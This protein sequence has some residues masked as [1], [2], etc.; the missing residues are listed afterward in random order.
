[1]VV[2]RNRLLGKYHLFKKIKDAGTAEEVARTPLAEE[3][4]QPEITVTPER[5]KISLNGTETDNGRRTDETGGDGVSSDAISSPDA[6][7][8]ANG[9]GKGNLAEQEPAEPAQDTLA[10]KGRGRPRKTP[11][12]EESVAKTAQKRSPA[13]TYGATDK[14]WAWNRLSKNARIATDG[15]LIIRYILDAQLFKDRG[16]ITQICE[17]DMDTLVKMIYGRARRCVYRECI[18]K[19]G[20]HLGCNYNELLFKAKQWQD[21]E[22]DDDTVIQVRAIDSQTRNRFGLRKN[23]LVSLGFKPADMVVIEQ[24]NDF[25][26]KSEGIRKGDI[27]LINKNDV[28][29]EL[30]KKYAAEINEKFYVGIGVNYQGKNMFVVDPSGT[31]FSNQKF[32][33]TKI[34]GKAVWIFA[35]I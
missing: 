25:M 18:D 2:V 12:E 3:Q 22:E 14:T 31:K 11:D 19:M 27:L 1:M 10:R 15:H 28:T 13:I 6:A 23:W 32:N 35:A 20:A 24:N 5:M 34:V 21:N 16:E 26:A 33:Q 30:G 9:R 8:A 17:C 29:F 7:R 4:Q